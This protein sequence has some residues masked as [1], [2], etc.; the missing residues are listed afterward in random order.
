MLRVVTLVSVICYLAAL[1]WNLKTIVAPLFSYMG[2]DYQPAG[3]K[4]M[5]TSFFIALLPVIWMPMRLV[6]PSIGTLHLLY[7]LLYV[8]ACIIPPCVLDRSFHFFLTYQLGILLSFAIL[9]VPHRLPLIAIRLPAQSA[10]VYWKAVLI[11]LI[12]FNLF[13]LRHFGFTISFHSLTRVYEVRQEFISSLAEASFFLPYAVFWQQKVLAPL[14]IIRGLQTRSVE[15]A[16]MGVFSELV[17]YSVT[18]LKGAVCLPVFL[19]AFYLLLTLS[20]RRLFL[21]MSLSL[22]GVV[23]CASL[24]DLWRDL[25][26]HAFFS[27]ILVRRNFHTPGLLTAYYYD[28]FSDN[29]KAWLGHSIL[30]SVVQYPYA[31]NPPDLIGM[32][33]FRFAHVSA[34]ANFW[35]DGFANFGMPGMVLASLLL[36]LVLYCFDSFATRIELRQAT[37]LL[38]APAMCL[39]DSGLLVTMC[40]HGLSLSLLLVFLMPRAETAPTA[41]SPRRPEFAAPAPSLKL[42]QR[43]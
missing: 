4:I 27:N 15:W 42:V 28:F 40:S 13:I 14:A 41:A 31:V 43:S 26:G 3:L 22:L 38:I 39:T 29:P 6:R 24:F 19:L 20:R 9:C 23:I 21:A 35:S 33:Y 10:V 11:L 2:Y 30:R 16:A 17:V 36:S 7:F 18:G 34:N 8:P 1:L 12:G 5:V 25:P 32:N 37:L